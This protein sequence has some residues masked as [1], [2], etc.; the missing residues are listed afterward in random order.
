M[1]RPRVGVRCEYINTLENLFIL[2]PYIEQLF[3]KIYEVA[4]HDLIGRH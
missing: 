2:L 4:V 3:I 1:L